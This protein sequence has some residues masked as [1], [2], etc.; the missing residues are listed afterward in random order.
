ML[1]G[2]VYIGA[3]ALGISVY[4]GVTGL[5]VEQGVRKEQVRVQIEGEKVA[6]K[7]DRAQRDSARKP[8]PSVLD[9]WSID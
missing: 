3:I 1:R 4:F 8:A 5:Y 6:K 9:K 2:A 7:I